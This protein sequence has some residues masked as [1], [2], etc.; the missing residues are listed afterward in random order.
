MTSHWIFRALLIGLACTRFAATAQDVRPPMLT[1]CEAL[2]HPDLYD[3]RMVHVTGR[4]VGGNEGAWMEGDGCPRA[5]QTEGYAWPSVISLQRPSAHPDAT[6]LH[7][8][9]FVF[10]LESE[11][12]LAS[13]YRK[14]RRRVAAEC[15]SFTYTGLFETRLDW[16]DYRRVFASG[17]VEFIGFGH[18]SSAPAQLILRSKDD[19]AQIPNCKPKK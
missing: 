11:R 17:R 15:V 18:L 4:V 13:K 10:D 8:T 6:H 9:D 1:V 19:A 2:S 14:L 3:G 7:A 12:T 5:Y 16:S